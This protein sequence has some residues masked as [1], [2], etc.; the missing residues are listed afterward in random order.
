M[1]QTAHL[2]RVQKLD[3]AL[4]HNNKR[5]QEIDRLLDSDK[6]IQS[7]KNQIRTAKIDSQKAHQTLR[8][9]EEN[10]RSIQTKIQ[11]SESKLYGGKITN[12]KEL[13]DI[14]NEIASLKRHLSNIEDEQL[15]AMMALE[16]YEQK[17][18]Q[19]ETDLIKAQAD[20]SQKSAGLLGEKSQIQKENE[21][22]SKERSATVSFVSDD[23]LELY[24]N[25]RANKNGRPMAIIEDQC[26]AACGTSLRPAELQSAKSIKITYCPSCGR[27]LYAG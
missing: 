22:L 20:F 27:I 2:Y 13:Q 14:Q 5:I 23:A 8:E 11:I 25:L 3:L 21:R 6:T 26:C 16:N 24:Q 15:E 7:A 9:I 12:P 18:K 19:A 10:S 4:D 17:L 1:N